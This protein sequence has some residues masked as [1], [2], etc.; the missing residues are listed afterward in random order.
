MLVADATKALDDVLPAIHRIRKT[1]LIIT[2]DLSCVTVHLVN[3]SGNVSLFIHNLGF[4]DFFSLSP[5]F[6]WFKGKNFGP[7]VRKQ[8]AGG[9]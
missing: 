4:V 7:A 6:W 3:T 1:F 5:H 8:W 9:S 2:N